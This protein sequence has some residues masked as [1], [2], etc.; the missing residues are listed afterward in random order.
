MNTDFIS[1]QLSAL[2]SLEVVPEEGLLKFLITRYE[3]AFKSIVLDIPSYDSIGWWQH[4]FAYARMLLINTVRNEKDAIRLLAR[5]NNDYGN[6]GLRFTGSL[7]IVIRSLDKLYRLE[8]LQTVTS[9]VTTESQ[10]DA[11]ED[12]FNYSILAYLLIAGE[13]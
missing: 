7:G 6:K 1:S 9:K 2:P 3:M 8:N 5:K 10:A 13:L 12:L 11:V 4:S